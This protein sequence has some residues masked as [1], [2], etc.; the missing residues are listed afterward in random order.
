MTFLAELLRSSG[1]VPFDTAGLEAATIIT[2]LCSD[3]L[4]EVAK[5]QA[6]VGAWRGSTLVVEPARRDR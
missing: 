3:I 5:V 6:Y 2:E 4:E 1:Y